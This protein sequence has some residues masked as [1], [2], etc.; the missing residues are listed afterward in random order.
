MKKPASLKPNIKRP[1]PKAKASRPRQRAR[2]LE[3]VVGREV[4]QTW[5]DML[6]RLVPD[7]RTH[8][9][10]PLVAAMLQYARAVAADQGSANEDEHSVVTSLLETT[11]VSDASEVKARLHDVVTK[12]S[13][14]PALAFSV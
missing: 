1:P 9:L 7:G 14:T 11:E 12:R 4:Y 10:A 5:V 6:R 2:S 8:R 13:K 3:A